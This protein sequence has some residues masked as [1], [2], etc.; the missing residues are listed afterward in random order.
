VMEKIDA[1]WSNMYHTIAGVNLALEYIDKQKAIFNPINYDIIKGELLGLRAFLH[2]DLMR[3]FSYGNLANREMSGELAVPYITKYTKLPTERRS[4]KQTFQLL[5][6][7]LQ[8]AAELLK[9][10]PI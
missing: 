1:I 8:K 6:D 5:L 9:T 4:Y 10:D 3:L 2:F 7:D